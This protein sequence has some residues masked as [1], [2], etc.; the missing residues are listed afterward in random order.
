[1]AGWHGAERG[2][3]AVVRWLL[4][5]CLVG[6]APT[7]GQAQPPAE[8]PEEPP[9]VRVIIDVSGSMRHNDPDQL[10][11]SALELLASLLPDGTRAGVWTFGVRVDNPLP[12]AEVEDAWRE[13]A[14]A[15]RPALVEY[16]PFTDIEA[17]VREAAEEPA[18]GWNHLILLTDGM[19]DLS[20]SRGPKPAVDDASRRRLLDELAPTLVERGV[21]VHAIAFS[22]EADLDLVERLSRASGG[23]P[24]L[25]QSPESLLGAFL[26][27]AERIF[28]ADQ[29]PLVEGRFVIEPGVEAFSALL[30]HDPASA[31]LG[32]V[33]P[34]G[35]R[36]DA[37]NPPPGA[38]WQVEPRFDLVRVPDPPPGEW[39]LE[40]EVGDSRIEVTSSLSLHTSE[41]PATLFLDF[42]LPVEAWLTRGG[43]PWEGAPEG[44]AATAELL[45]GAERVQARVRLSRQAE[46]FVGEL[47]A[48]TQPGAARLRLRIEGEGLSRQR[49]QAVNVLPAIAAR[50]EPGSSRVVLEALHPELDHASAR[51]W[52]E[53]AGERLMAEPA[54][55][56][57]WRIAL[58]ELDPRVSQPMRL[59]AE[60]TLDGER[61]ELDLPRLLLFP[62]AEIGLGLAGGAGP[63]PLGERF[64]L[65][66]A[67]G[68]EGSES[69]DSAADRFVAFV[70]ELTA[71]TVALWREGGPGLARRAEA[72]GDPRLLAT[73]GLAV[74]V[75]L[76][77]LVLLVLLVWRPRRAP[78]RAPH[79]EDPHV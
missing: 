44:L 72:F 71:R 53:L 66:L 5:A 37:D 65:D 52:G 43:E 2:G 69:P 31:A 28:P 50:H 57:A 49:A 15:L 62:E 29:V 58:P 8:T 56:Q 4:V 76:I 70:D 36:H 61:R 13:R 41:L 51:P 75:L 59:R 10:A 64:H 67:T 26:D 60:V 39:R 34:D 48:P 23:L 14:M 3:G 54:A 33:A 38:S 47:P 11:A 55:A 46:R 17:A 22:D 78:R 30:F 7:L 32:L 27:I 40:G 9:E 16:Q 68:R 24:A 21:V 63:G 19:I 12:P 6:L 42:P 79:R 73:A 18:S 77:L 20:P 35:T 74:L 45:D 25:V 1:M